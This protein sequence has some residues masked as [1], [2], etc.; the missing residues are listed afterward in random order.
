MS[1][2]IGTQPV[3]QATQTRDSFTATANQT[4][5]AT[6]GYTPEFLDVFLNGVKLAASDYT[7]TNGSDVVLAS[8]AAA[9]DILEVVAYS[10][11]EVLNPTFDG[12]V[13]FTGNASFGDNDK[14]IFG[15]GSDLQIYHNGSNSYIDDAGSGDLYVR[16]SGNL[17]LTNSNGADT[18]A[19]FQESGYAKLYH[20]GS[21]KLAT[22]STGVNVTGTATAT[23]LVSTNGV[24]ELDDDGS[25]N[26]IINSPAS[27]RINIDSD[28]NSTGESFVVGHNQTSIDSNNIL[29]K[30][31]DDGKVGIG[32]TSPVT[33]LDVVTTS[34][35]TKA[36]IRSNTNSSPSAGLEL[37]RGTTSTFGADAYT[38]CLI[39]NINGGHLTFSNATSGTTSERMR[40]HAS[41]GISFGTGNDFG[42]VTSFCTQSGKPA[43]VY[44]D[45]EGNGNYIIFQNSS[46]TTIGSITRSSSSTV[47]A[48]SSDYRLKENVDYT[49]D[50]TTRLKQ[51][52]PAR[53]NWIADDTNTL[54]DG[55]LAHEVATVVPEAIIGTH[56]EVEVW[57]DGDE[58]PDGVT[59]GDNKLDDDGNTIP[60]YQ[61]I[62]QSKLVPLLTA[63]LQEALTEIAS[64]KT[65]VEALEA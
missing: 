31:Q 7:A 42:S 29:L 15:D 48:T 52:K 46:N 35:G 5:F 28:N 11:F 10:T 18:Y 25:H 26:G 50:A 21:E 2:Y 65:R 27:M 19:H 51:L 1:G 60:V 59:V 33:N 38:D 58:L 41:G 17:R 56:N 32:T 20:N 54:V 3:P 16:A 62:D 57:K 22:T 8:G 23:K 4:S 9:S 39:E 36:R 30:V 49:W 63:A 24:L 55:F 53:F 6:S 34:A 43:S 12:N 13:T 64:L 37:C 14:A 44:R 47:Y 61:G 40:I 45:I